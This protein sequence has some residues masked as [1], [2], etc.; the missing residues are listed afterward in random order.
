MRVNSVS[1]MQPAVVRSQCE[2]FAKSLDRNWQVVV[3]SLVLLC[4]LITCEINERGSLSESW[5]SEAVQ[6]L[7]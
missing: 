7:T 3:R 2:V 6:F 1:W 5:G 4:G